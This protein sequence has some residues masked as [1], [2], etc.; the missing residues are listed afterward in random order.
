MGRLVHIEITADDMA[1]AKEFYKIFDWEIV[2]SGMPG[3]DYWLAKTGEGEPGLDGAIMPRAYNPQP[4][5]HWI[6]VDD[7]DEMIEKVKT[8]GGKILGEKHSVPGIGDT[9]Y[10]SD[11]EG[12]TFGMIKALPRE[13]DSK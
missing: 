5:I 4:V 8:S 3:A 10:A 9:I 11:T 13:V 12:N 7:L 1:R 6:G 2:D